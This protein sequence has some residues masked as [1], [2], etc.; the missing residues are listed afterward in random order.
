MEPDAAYYHHPTNKQYSMEYV[1]QDYSDFL[2]RYR[3]KNDPKALIQE[4]DEEVFLLYTNTSSSGTT[5]NLDSSRLEREI[6]QMNASD[7][8]FALRLLKMFN[9]T[10]QETRDEDGEDILEIYKDL[11]IGRVSEVTDEI[12]W[13]GTVPE[14][15]GRV[16]SNL[17]LK[18]CLPNANHRTA[19][20]MMQ[21]YLVSA[22]LTYDLPETN[23]D[24]L[25]W[26]TWVNPYIIDSKRILTVR[27]NNVRFKS[28]QEVGCEYVLRK[29][30]IL[31]DLSQYELDMH[32]RYAWE[33][34]AKT[35]ENLCIDF[36]GEVI[37]R[38]EQPEMLTK[39]APQ[40]GK[41]IEHLLREVPEGRISG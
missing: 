23:T 6:D 7:Q 17:I 38:A 24:E 26:E 8:A 9:V 2:E 28:L 27:R 32:Y 13:E 37:K 10:D 40:K 15:A 21:E 25:D 3:H 11:E 19:I 34:Y 16:M 41:F 20:T 18:H 12:D 5:D 30:G 39:E 35:H 4:F 22:G 31:I 33:Y 1:G 29:G 14:V 36:A